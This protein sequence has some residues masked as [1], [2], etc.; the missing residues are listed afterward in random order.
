MKMGP[1]L[2]AAPPPPWPPFCPQQDPA[3]WLLGTDNIILG[4]GF[5]ETWG[6]DGMTDRAGPGGGRSLVRKGGGQNLF[7][8]TGGH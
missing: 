7:F 5:D 4:G 8:L 2:T 6:E 1:F 3:S